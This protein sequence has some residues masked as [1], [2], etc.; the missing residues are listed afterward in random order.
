VKLNVL[1]KKKIK[2]LVLRARKAQLI[3]KNSSFLVRKKLKNIIP[4]YFVEHQD[5]IVPVFVRDSGKLNFV[6]A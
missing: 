6:L 2:E 3:W 4:T 1:N 5:D